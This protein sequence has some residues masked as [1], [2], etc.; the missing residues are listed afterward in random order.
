MMNL[1]DNPDLSNFKIF[2]NLVSDLPMIFYALDVDWNF[3]LSDGKG[4][5]QLN[6]KPGQVLG[7]N[8]KDVYRDYPDLLDAL[9]KAYQGDIVHVEHTFGDIHLENFIIPVYSSSQKIEGIIGATINITKRKIIEFDLH[10]TQELQRAIIDCVPGMLYLYNEAG[11]LVFWNKSHESITGYSSVEL[12]HF[13]LSNWYKDDPESL[14]VVTNGLADTALKGFGEA[15]ANLQ[16]K[17]GSTI[18]MYFTACPIEIEGEHFFV[19]IGIDISTRKK[20]EDE[21]ILLNQTLEEKIEQRTLELSQSN[22]EL[23]ALNEQMI[24]MNDELT[25]ANEEMSAMNEELTAA[26]EEITAMNEELRESNEKIIEMKDYLVE[27]EK[28][29]ALGGLVAGVAH[30]V[31]T[32]LGVGITASSHLNDIAQELMAKIKEPNFDCKSLMDYL[33]DIQ[34]AALIIEKNLTRA[35]RLTQSFK[36]LSI[37]QISEPKRIF[38]VGEYLEEILISLSPSFKQTNIHVETKYKEN[39]F[40]NGSPGAFAQ[41]ITN[42]L[43]N[44]ILHAYDKHESGTIT[45]TIKKDHDGIKMIFSDDGHGMTEQTRLKIYDPFFTTRRDL[46][47]TGLGLSIVYSIITQQFSGTIKC[48]SKLGVGTTFTIM[49]AQGGN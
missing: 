13:P 15:E 18:P 37:D 30:E 4:L 40:L 24:A 27:S 39:L 14:G 11:E 23:T 16:K 42:L 8:A 3:T 41:I 45:I 33:E 43:M 7:L 46:G 5:E 21:L 25:G 9:A 26:N 2:Q 38:N 12:E 49:L 19:G 17:D 6:L 31:N 28:M 10:K 35:G 47:G 48:T 32:P 22:E 44:S 34:Q 29:A 1:P 20:A 36:Q